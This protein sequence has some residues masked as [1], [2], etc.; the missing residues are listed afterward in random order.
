MSARGGWDD[1]GAYCG[2][3]GE[4]GVMMLIFV[5]CPVPFAT[6]KGAEL[7]GDDESVQV[8]GFPLVQR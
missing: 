1:A 8:T 3:D 2:G 4:G 7:F 5:P 6:E